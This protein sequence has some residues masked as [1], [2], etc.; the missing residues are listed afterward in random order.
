MLDALFRIAYVLAILLCVSLRRRRGFEV[1][2]YLHFNV[3]QDNATLLGL[4]LD[5]LLAS[6]VPVAA[7]LSMLDEAVFGNE[8]LEVLH[9]DEVVVHTVLLPGAR[10]ACRVRYG[11]SEAFRVPVEQHVVQCALA[12]ARRAGEHDRAT[13]GRGY[14]WKTSVSDVVFSIFPLYEPSVVCS[15]CHKFW[16]SNIRVAMVL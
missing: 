8:V 10:G 11:E 7:E 3:E 12:D 14:S 13:I 1:G 9:G 5:G 15:W 2:H 4:L 16:R 6:T